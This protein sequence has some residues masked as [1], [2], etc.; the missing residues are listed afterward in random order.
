MK[1]QKV[2][3]ETAKR[4]LN[5]L[6]E[7]GLIVKKVG[8]GSFVADIGPKK[9]IWGFVVPIYTVHY[10]DCIQEF[11]NRA[12]VLGKEECQIDEK[13]NSAGHCQLSLRQFV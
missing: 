5:M 12:A 8:Q 7:K 9:P 2:A 13:C 3:R 6:A 11:R 1:S 10:D 4:C